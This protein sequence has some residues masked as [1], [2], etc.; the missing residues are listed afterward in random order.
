MSLPFIVLGLIILFAVSWDVVEPTEFGLKY[1]SV[2][3]TVDTRNP[4]SGGRYIIGPGRRF[5]K[6]P[7]SAAKIEFSDQ[8]GADLGPIH[9]RTGRDLSDP[10]SGGQPISISLAIQYRLPKDQLGAMYRKFAMDWHYRHMQFAQQVVSVT[11]QVR[12]LEI[13]I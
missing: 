9:C 13:E 12:P 6:F 10:D 3:G 5:L 8:E 4:Y 2:T 11:A 7:A 1:N